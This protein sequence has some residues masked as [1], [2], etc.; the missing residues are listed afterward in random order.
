MRLHSKLGNL[1]SQIAQPSNAIPNDFRFS[2]PAALPEH[3]TAES[4]R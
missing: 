2:F 1:V 4:Y 3:F